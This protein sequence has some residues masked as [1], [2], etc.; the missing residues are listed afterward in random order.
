MR[1]TK[2]LNSSICA[3]SSAFALTSRKRKMRPIWMS[4]W[5]KSLSKKWKSACK[6]LK[7]SMP[8]NRITATVS[9]ATR[10]IWQYQQIDPKDSNKSNSA[11]KNAKTWKSCWKHS[12]RLGSPSPRITRLSTNYSRTLRSW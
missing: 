3:F 4:L 6:F 2:F 7:K 5:E 11:N 9:L 8:S 10:M 1:A 12:A